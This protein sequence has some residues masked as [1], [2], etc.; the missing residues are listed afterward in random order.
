MLQRLIVL[1]ALWYGFSPAAFAADETAYAPAK[2]VYDVSTSDAAELGR[3]LDR[4]SLLQ[5]L[6]GVDPFEA[7][8]VIVVHEG[9]IPLFAKSAPD[10]A[11]DLMLRASSLAMGEVIHFR[12]CSAS[13]RMQGYSSEDFHEF[14]KMVPMADAEIVRLQNEGY[15]YLR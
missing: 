5:T 13:A 15:A 3:I 12:L 11:H 4:A 8:I 9:A 7:A 10:Q 6:Y 1:C 2:A 14:M